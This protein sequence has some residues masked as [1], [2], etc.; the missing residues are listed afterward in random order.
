M[1]KLGD[2]FSKIGGNNFEKSDD[3]NLRLRNERKR[4]FKNKENINKYG[5]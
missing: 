2:I 1:L 5:L 3:N 4:K